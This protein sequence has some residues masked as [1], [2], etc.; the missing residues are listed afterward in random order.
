MV[1]AV[2]SWHEHHERAAEAIESR[3]NRR[4]RMVVAEAALIET[5][6]VLTRF[7]APHRLSPEMALDVLEAN[8]LKGVKII[9]LEAEAYC[10]LLRGAPAAAVSGGL[11]YD[12]VIA[13]CA[14]KERS[15]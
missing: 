9:A 12:A 10:A 7:P 14:R 1:A 5:Y 6:S 2:C 8:F 13:A 11:T 3:L 15:E 4:E